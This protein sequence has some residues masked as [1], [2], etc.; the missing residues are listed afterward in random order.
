MPQPRNVRLVGSTIGATVVVVLLALAAVAIF[1]GFRLSTEVTYGDLLVGVGTL[2]LAVFTAALAF[3]TFGLDERTALRDKERHDREVLGVARLLVAELD[4]INDTLAVIGKER[5]WPVDAA[6]P[7]SAWSRSAELL[8]TEVTAAD[9]FTLVDFFAELDG[10]AV[11]AGR[12]LTRHPDLNEI[13]LFTNQSLD[14]AL[15]L[16][17]RAR[18]IARALADPESPPPALRRLWYR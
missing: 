2:A 18:K 14:R 10:W 11:W 5:S 15:E 13:P 17:D 12:A 8:L 1:Q 7:R 9:G 16:N 6:L 4:V 3:E